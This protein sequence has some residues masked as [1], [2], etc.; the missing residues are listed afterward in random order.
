MELRVLQYFLAVA[1]EENITRAA[2]RFA[3]YAADAFPPVDAAGTGTGGEAVLQGRAC[4]APD[5]RRDASAAARA[6]NG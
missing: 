5:G 3:Y 1:E 2:A 4:G 6:G